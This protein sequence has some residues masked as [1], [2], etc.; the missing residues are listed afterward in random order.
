VACQEFQWVFSARNRS[1]KPGVASFDFFREQRRV[2]V[3]SFSVLDPDFGP[4]FIKIC[5]YFPY[6]AR[7]WLNGH[8][9]ATRQADHAGIDFTALSNGFASCPEPQRLQT[10]CDGFAP[11]HIQAFFDRWSACIPTPFTAQDRAAGYSRARARSSYCA[12]AAHSALGKLA[13]T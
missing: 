6:P 3:F 12:E 13:G 8:E 10:V 11:G 5:T 1:H 2:G 9:W 7:V 4:G